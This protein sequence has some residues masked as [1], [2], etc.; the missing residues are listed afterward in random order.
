[1]ALPIQFDWTLEAIPASEQSG[2]ESVARVLEGF[3]LQGVGQHAGSE[4]RGEVVLLHPGEERLV[5]RHARRSRREV[6][7][8]LASTRCPGGFAQ[9]RKKVGRDA[10]T[11]LLGGRVNQRNAIAPRRPVRLATWSLPDEDVGLKIEP[12]LAESL[13]VRIDRDA[14]GL[15]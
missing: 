2:Q 15:L 11:N 13:C 12:P 4:P 14:A 9:R 5:K 1:M 7:Q 6:M 3:L 8:I 10:P